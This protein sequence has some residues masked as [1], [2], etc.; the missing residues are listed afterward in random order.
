[1]CTT[2]STAETVLLAFLH[3]G[4]ASEKSVVAERLEIF[5]CEAYESTSETHANSTGLAH[6]AATRDTCEHIDFIGVANVVEGLGDEASFSVAGE[7]FFE[8][9][10]VDGDLSGPWAN[11]NASDAGLSTTGSQAISGDLVFLDEHALFSLGLYQGM[12]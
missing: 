6:W 4:I 1:L 11:A 2:A 8:G 12:K 3:S 10:I 9:S 7:I 5:F